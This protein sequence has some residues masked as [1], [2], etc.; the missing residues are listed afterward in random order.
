M[1]LLMVRLVILGLVLSIILVFLVFSGG[2]WLGYIFRVVI[3]LW[4]L[5]LM[6]VIVMCICFVCSGVC[7]FG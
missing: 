3:I 2:V 6:V 7:I 1:V 5:I 4:K